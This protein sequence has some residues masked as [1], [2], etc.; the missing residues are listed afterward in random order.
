MM[1][2]QHSQSSKSNSGHTTLLKNICSLPHGQH[3][4]GSKPRKLLTKFNLSSCLLI[5]LEIQEMT[6][7]WL[8]I[9]TP[10][11]VSIKVTDTYIFLNNK[12]Q[13]N[14]L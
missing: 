1:T 6:F 11:H 3:G 4:M 2:Y 12:K 14:L 5:S 13:E 10:G 7:R 9:L 8:S